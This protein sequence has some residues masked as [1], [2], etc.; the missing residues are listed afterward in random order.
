MS[1]CVQQKNKTK[2]MATT[3]FRYCRYCGFWE[4]HEI[5]KNKSAVY[6]NCLTCTRAAYIYVEVSTYVPNYKTAEPILHL[7]DMRQ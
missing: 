1:L 3:F 2:R 5:K 7:K 6:V 4:E